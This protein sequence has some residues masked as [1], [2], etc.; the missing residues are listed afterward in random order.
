MNTRPSAHVR[1]GH[2][3]DSCRSFGAPG[4][5][6]D[7]RMGTPFFYD[8][9][10]KML[11]ILE[12]LNRPWF[13]SGGWA[14]FVLRTSGYGFKSTDDLPYEQWAQ[15][16][17][18]EQWSMDNDMDFTI[19]FNDEEDQANKYREVTTLCEQE[20]GL[21]CS[22]NKEG[23]GSSVVWE[24]SHRLHFALWGA[25]INGSEYITIAEIAGYNYDLPRSRILP[26]K[27]AKFH[28][29]WIRVPRDS[30]WTFSHLRPYCV[31][32]PCDAA[33]DDRDV[34]YGSGCMKMAYPEFLQ[35]SAG[36][37]AHAPIN[38]TTN[39]YEDVRSLERSLIGCAE[40]LER[41]RCASFAECFRST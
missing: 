8:D 37:P 11:S 40:C 23:N 39:V 12:A 27:Y 9:W 3:D 10:N 38:S 17:G 36:I 24:S 13:A 20:N 15:S 1:I 18:E 41:H 33:S 32:P 16:I 6:D 2:T 4:C 25:Y 19:V 5:C 28:D 7:I 35:G 14:L 31:Y 34:E 22:Y 30:L 21:I 29:S 26:T